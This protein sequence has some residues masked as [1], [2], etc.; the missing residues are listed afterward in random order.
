MVWTDP[1]LFDEGGVFSE[2]TQFVLEVEAKYPAFTH[3]FTRSDTSYEAKLP[4]STVLQLLKGARRK[5]PGADCHYMLSP[6]S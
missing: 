5:C 1:E 3:K 4:D 2:I 6:V